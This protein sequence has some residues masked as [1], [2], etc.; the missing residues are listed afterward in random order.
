MGVPYVKIYSDSTHITEKLTRYESGFLFY[1]VKMM[2]KGN[3]VT[4]NSGVK[5]LAMIVL[6]CTPKALEKALEGLLKAG[7][8]VKIS[9]TRYFVSPYIF[10]LAEW[11]KVI[12]LRKKY[13]KLT[14]AQSPCR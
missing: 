12:K 10:A 5:G 8:L 6:G 3:L 2:T 4:V 14:Q 13:D 11:E 1:L 7:A 9:D